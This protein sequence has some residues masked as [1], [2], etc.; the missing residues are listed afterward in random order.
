MPALGLEA[1]SVP[2]PMRR[3][4]ARRARA[5][6]S[7]DAADEAKLVFI[8]DQLDREFC[9]TKEFQLD[10]SLASALDWTLARTPAEVV[11]E[12]EEILQRI[13]RAAAHFRASG[14]TA[15]WLAGSDPLVARVSASVNGPFCAWLAGEVGWSDAEAVDTLR[16]GAPLLGVLPRVGLGAPINEGAV[17]DLD[18]LRREA[19]KKN[20]AL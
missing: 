5:Q 18:A 8:R 13:E 19:R 16:Y 15:A 2:P 17:A 14:A 4:G 12:R 20:A 7:C 6:G 10:A 1:T 9:F 11:S 3:V